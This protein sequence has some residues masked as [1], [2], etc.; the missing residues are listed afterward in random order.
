MSSLITSMPIW[1]VFVASLLIGLLSAYLGAYYSYM[2]EQRGTKE[3][4]PAGGVAVTAMLGLLAFML[5]FT[6]STTSSRYADRKTLVINQATA[7]GTCYLRAQFIPQKQSVASRQIL[8]DYINM[9]L[10]TGRVSSV[11]ASLRAVDSLNGQLWYHAAS[12][13]GDTMDSELRSLYIASVNQVLD[14]FTERKTVALIFRINNTIWT[15]LLLLYIL[16]MIVVGAEAG[17]SKSRRIFYVPVM[18]A[19]FALVIALIAEMDSS[20]RRGRFSANL[21]PLIDIQNMIHR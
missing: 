13:A 1:L 5:G 14:V 18:C 8:S 9:M 21:Q 12:L 16:S 2:R 17:T 10:Q 15:V 3:R 7:I 4:D 19:A 20:T 11:H 6:F